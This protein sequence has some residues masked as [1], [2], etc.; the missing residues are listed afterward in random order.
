MLEMIRP[1]RCSSDILCD[2]Y[3]IPARSSSTYQPARPGVTVARACGGCTVCRRGNRQPFAAPLPALIPSWPTSAAIGSVLASL[4]QRQN[5]D[6]AGWRSLAIFFDE[7]RPLQLRRFVRW[8]SA[9]GIRNVVMP[10]ET[11][12]EYHEALADLTGSGHF[13]FTFPLDEFRFFRMPPMPTLLFAHRRH[14]LK[15]TLIARL[16]GVTQQEQLIV[17]VA[18]SDAPDPRAPHRLLRHTLSGRTY[19]FEE[20]SLLVGL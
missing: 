15:E 3:D 11:L 6:G 10:R 13:V 5:E 1:T 8:L 20:F 17:V 4:A 19:Q 18:P 12:V 2:A 7:I 14:Q 16:D 9:Q